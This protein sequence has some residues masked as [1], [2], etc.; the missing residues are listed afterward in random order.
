MEARCGPRQQD[1]AAYVWQ[2]PQGGN[3]R[4]RDKRQIACPVSAIRP[5][6]GA[7]SVI[8]EHIPTPA[9]HVAQR[10][11]S[12]CRDGVKGDR[13]RL[14]ARA[15]R[16]RHGDGLSRHRRQAGRQIRNGGR[17]DKRLAGSSRQ[18]PVGVIHS[19]DRRRAVT[20]H[21]AQVSEGDAARE[22][23]RKRARVDRS[24]HVQRGR[25]RQGDCRRKADRL[26]AGTL[27]GQ[28]ALIGACVSNGRLG[29][30]AGHNR[31]VN[32]F[33][34]DRCIAQLT[35]RCKRRGTVVAGCI[36][37]DGIP[38]N[39]TADKFVTRIQIRSRHTGE[40][41]AQ[42]IGDVAGHNEAREVAQSGS[43]R[44]RE[45]AQ[46]ARNF[47][48]PHILLILSA[49]ALITDQHQGFSN[50]GQLGALALQQ[51]NRALAL[52]V[53]VVEIAG[54]LR[55]AG[56]VALDFGLHVG[57]P[58]KR[59]R[60]KQQC[61][62]AGIARRFADDDARAA[63]RVRVG[64]LHTEAD[65]TQVHRAGDAAQLGDVRKNVVA[66]VIDDHLA[67]ERAPAFGHV[68]HNLRFQELDILFEDRH[69]RFPSA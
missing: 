18:H 13:Q 53:L 19:A 8:R 14:R 59:A 21:P 26:F 4:A 12:R 16:D 28:Q 1:V 10:H 69:V 15:G 63:V 66:D 30:G 34:A 62:Y 56:Q 54:P 33:G 43:T 52:D 58:V 55:A 46:L 57:A 24:T 5:T 47:C 11:G 22:G 50:G 37:D 40:V 51:H 39:C 20:Q 65:Q 49:L 68:F 9:H 48:H 6:Q 38:H 31:G 45:L 17:A 27:H 32:A 36:C 41:V 64:S 35:G 2:C 7:R 3:Q 23:H 67:R 42:R 61:R 44:E 29:L 60:L 25:W